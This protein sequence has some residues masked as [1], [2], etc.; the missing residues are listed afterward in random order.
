M[1]PKQIDITTE[2]VPI[3]YLILNE[4]LNNN[5]INAFPDW[6]KCISISVTASPMEFIAPFTGYIC[7]KMRYENTSSKA[8][9]VCEGIKVTLS[10]ATGTPAWQQGMY[11]PCVKGKTIYFQYAAMADIYLDLIKAIGVN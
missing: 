4:T 8:L 5:W 10:S 2:G 1:I 11:V 7:T 3:N 6:A 9:L